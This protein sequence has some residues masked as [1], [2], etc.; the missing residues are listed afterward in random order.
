[1]PE[2]RR[3]DGV[4]TLS[5]PGSE[6][7]STGP[8]GG[9]RRADAAYNVSVPEGF[10]RTDLDAYADERLA[11]AGFE[12][13]GPA[14]LTGV[15]MEHARCARMPL[16]GDA[17]GTVLAVATAGVS[18]PAP[19][20]PAADGAGDGDAAPQTA[21]DRPP[22]TVNVL[23]HVDRPLAA[24]ALANLAAVVAEAKAA[25]L[26]RETGVPG[27]TTDAAIVGC[28]AVA[29]A[30]ADG[31]SDTARFSGTGTPVGAAARACVRDAVRASLDSR[32]ADRS[33]PESVSDA[34]H[35]VAP[36]ARA[37]VFEP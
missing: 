7:L 18:N 11:D 27:T 15:A 17:A 20:F 21:D 35:G 2:L 29:D 16:E 33:I 22:G 37:E 13:A 26:L 14:L 30:P 1:M 9:R 24:G 8:D 5:A 19:L 10:D 3:R 28:P 12:A 31:E 25:T 36:P 32:Y 34:E 6:W 4:L 23:L